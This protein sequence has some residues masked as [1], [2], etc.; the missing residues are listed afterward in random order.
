MFRL[1]L[2]A[3]GLGGIPTGDCRLF[4]RC[5]NIDGS[6]EDAVVP[7]LASPTILLGTLIVNRADV[8][9][10]NI[11]GPFRLPNYKTSSEFEFYL[12]NNMG[13]TTG[14]GWELHVIPMTG[15]PHP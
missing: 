6:T 7:S 5:M 15:G 14:T 12:E 13:V 3:T 9:Q 2:T 4:A 8:D 11:H 1:V 10:E